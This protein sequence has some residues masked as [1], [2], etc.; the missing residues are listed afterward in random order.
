MIQ[1][2][3]L[4]MLLTCLTAFFCCA[5]TRAQANLSSDDIT[6]TGKKTT[7]EDLKGTEK[8]ASFPKSEIMAVVST[9]KPAC[10]RGTTEVRFDAAKGFFEGSESLSTEELINRVI[11][12]KEAGK[13]SCLAVYAASYNKQTFDRL[14][15]ALVIPHQ[16]SLMWKTPDKSK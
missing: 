15:A 6:V 8:L 11:T 3:R 5:Q 12:A 16:I 4:A 2:A 10:V 7:D 14:D 9:G 1:L 13:T